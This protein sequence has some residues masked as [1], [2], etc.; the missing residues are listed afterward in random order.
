MI[1]SPNSVRPGAPAPAVDTG[2]RVSAV[3]QATEAARTRIDTSGSALPPAPHHS[4]QQPRVEETGQFHK[5]AVKEVGADI[6]IPDEGIDPARRKAAPEAGQ[7]AEGEERAG[8]EGEER[9]EGDRGAEGQEGAEGEGEAESDLVVAL[10][11]RNEGEEE[12]EI[13]VTDPAVAERLRQLKNSA[14]RGDEARGVLD[15]ARQAR[16][17]VEEFEDML[18]ADPGGMVLGA[19]KDDPATLQHLALYILT[20]PDIWPVMKDKLAALNDPSKFENMQL[21]VENERHELAQNFQ[22]VAAER[23]AVQQNY[24]QLQ[25]A[26]GLIMP[27]EMSEQQ[28]GVFFADALR[29]IAAYADRTRQLTV[30]PADVPLILAARMTASG[31][32]PVKAAQRLA[33]GRATGSNR[34]SGNGTRD[35]KPAPKGA[36][37]RERAPQRTGAQMVE[38]ARRRAVAARVPGGGAGSEGMGL[39]KPP[40]DPKLGTS[41][42]E[43]ATEWHR[44]QLKLRQSATH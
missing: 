28:K 11:A 10:P 20:R 5:S 8:A 16:E 22:S 26:V 42:T 7:G 15:E 4:Q 1:E 3:D 29:D 30:N 39:Q 33:S 6:E 23:K 32:D 41:A 9:G 13:E 25:S 31:I 14:M 43:Q 40:F 18:A 12:V 21:R 36:A 19:L 34:G 27:P 38:G 2:T 35:G 24:T 37:P 17:Q 44:Q